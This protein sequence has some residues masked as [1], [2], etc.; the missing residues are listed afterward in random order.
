MTLKSLSLYTDCEIFYDEPM[1][2]HTTLG[3]GGKA[4]YYIKVRSVKDLQTLTEYFLHGNVP[5]KIIGNGSNLLVGDK[6]FRGAIINLN[7]LCRIERSEDVVTVGAGVPINAFIDFC[8]ENDVACSS[9][10]F[11]IPASIGGALVMNA[12]A[13]G[14]NI[15][16]NLLC[17]RT[18]KNGKIVV[19]DKNQCGFGYRTSK[20]KEFGE[21]IISATFF[22]RYKTKE[23]IR[24][25][26]ETAI[27]SR[28]AVQPFGKTCG[29]VF[30]NPKGYSAGQLIDGVE[31]KGYAFGGA[32]ISKK[33]ANFII[34]E[35]G[36]TAEEVRDLIK[37]IKR[38]VKSTFGVDLIE[39]VEYVGEF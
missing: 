28:K 17:V 6:G 3:V 2:K 16:D 29:S 30:K 7:G 11:G 12:G 20:L 33:H 8:L 27:I 34:N 39:E 14:Q 10:L 19:Y 4:D 18:L 37:Y 32:S 31:L 24:R 35:G 15:S 13:F 22:G 25:E 23:S 38:K 21:P 1:S 26:K 9:A 36:A 5:Y